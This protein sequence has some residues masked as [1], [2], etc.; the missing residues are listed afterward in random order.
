MTSTT[1]S[2]GLNNR[3][4]PPPV[5]VILFDLDDTLTDRAAS[6]RAYMRR[7]V[8]DF[9]ERLALRDEATL[10]AEI[11][12]IDRG[13]YNPT[14]SAELAAHAAWISSPGESALAEH[15]DVHFAACTAGRAGLRPTI[16]TLA[17][18]GLQLG[19]VTNGKTDR[20]RRKIDALGIRP[21]LQSIA[22]SE[23][24][25]LAKPDARIFHAAA[26]EL[27]A[28]PA[29]CIFVGDNPEKD[30][31]GAQAA[32]MRAVWL[33]GVMPWPEHLAV[34]PEAIAAL[35]EILGLPGLGQ[36]R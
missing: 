34:P 14:R 21:Q 29:A 16:D 36:P 24:R 26:A 32:G 12:R 7:F 2:G 18:R 13:G 10:V 31:L 9:G 4:Q 15:W 25:G 6:L 35:E 19:V 28:A 8:R 30:V 11:A 3:S 23:E 33:S 1:T 20:Q 22:I 5:Q 27:R 17:L